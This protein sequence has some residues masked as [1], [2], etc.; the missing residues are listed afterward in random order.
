MSNFIGD[1]NCKLDA[2][3][4]LL[5]P[6]AFK[7]QMEPG[8]DERFVIKKDIYEKCLVLY[9]MAEWIR[10]SNYIKQQIN[11]FDKE[12]NKF[13]REYLKGTAEV[14]LDANNRILVPKRL[15]DLIE[16]EKEVVLAGQFDKIEIW[17][18]SNYD[19]VGDDEV[20]YEERASKIMGG[21]KS[22]PE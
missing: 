20:A 10:Q 3:G 17:A 14:S 16:A 2:K 22:K 8:E 1:H 18:K 12:S 15:L 9:P 21:N 6:S 19:S 4:R 13:L 5:M 7:K 11:P